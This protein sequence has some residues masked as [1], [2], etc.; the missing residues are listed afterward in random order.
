MEA[1]SISRT[2]TKLCVNIRQVRHDKINKETIR[3]LFQKYCKETVVVILNVKLLPEIIHTNW[4]GCSH[5][6]PSQSEHEC[7]MRDKA[8]SV[9]MYFDEIMK[10][11]DF[12]LVNPLAM[13][14]LA[15]KHPD[16]EIWEAILNFNTDLESYLKD[17]R[18]CGHKSNPD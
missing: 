3:K 17:K 6:R 1:P 5:D 12:L 8:E 15:E 9:C 14:R 4:F 10:K 18:L 2:G 13:Q 11:V 16:E 7:T